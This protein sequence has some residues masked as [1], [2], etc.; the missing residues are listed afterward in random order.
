MAPSTSLQADR[1]HGTLLGLA[2][3]NSLG[4]P[5]EFL[6]AAGSDGSIRAA[7]ARSSGEDDATPL[8]DDDLAQ[9]VILA[10]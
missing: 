9:A 7:C 1:Y 8:A 4:L 6:T 10:R 3:G 2:V 5:V